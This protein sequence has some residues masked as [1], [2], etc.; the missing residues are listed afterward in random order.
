MP[1]M[2]LVIRVMHEMALVIRVLH[3]VQYGGY[4]W[5]HEEIKS[6]RA[7]DR[8]HMRHMACHIVRLL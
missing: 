8:L 5:N 6:F 3:V 7:D 1:E 2:P 4:L